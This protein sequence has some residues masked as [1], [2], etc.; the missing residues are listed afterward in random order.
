M[1]QICTGEFAVVTYMIEVVVVYFIPMLGVLH[2]EV[3]AGAD[4][5][6][7]PNNVTYHLLVQVPV[8]YMLPVCVLQV[9]DHSSIT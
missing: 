8:V 6:E 1:I 5:E 4:E 7:I 9:R 3:V 2:G